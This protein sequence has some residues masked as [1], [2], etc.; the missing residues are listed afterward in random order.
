MQAYTV[1]HES[2]FILD[3]DL[4]EAAGK[5]SKGTETDAGLVELG[6]RADY[7]RREII[8]SVSLQDAGDLELAIQL[9]VAWP[10]QDVKLECR[11]LVRQ[12]LLT[13]CV[14]SMYN[15]QVFLNWPLMHY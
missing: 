6:V 14:F 7:A 10:L 8:A 1:K 15:A 2:S 3:C 13:H 9:P 12:L 5:A 4:A 11:K